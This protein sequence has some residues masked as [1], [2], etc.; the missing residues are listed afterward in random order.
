MQKSKSRVASH[1]EKHINSNSIIVD[2]T[3]GNGH[4][5]L[6]LLKSQIGACI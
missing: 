4:D 2:A 5:T 3:C 1:N 6:F